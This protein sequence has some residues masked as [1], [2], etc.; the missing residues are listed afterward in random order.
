MLTNRGCQI[1]LGAKYQNG[2]KCTK[3]PQ[4]ITNGHKNVSN[5]NKIDPMS[6]KYT[7]F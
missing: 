6:N 1:F 3:L 7:N 4:N 2:G 5:G